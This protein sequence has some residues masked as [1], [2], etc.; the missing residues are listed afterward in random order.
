MSIQEP[1]ATAWLLLTSGALLALGVLM[2]RASRRVGVPVFLLFIALGMLAGSEGL[3]GIAFE[4]YHLSFRLGSIALALILFDGGLNTRWSTCKTAIRP[5]SVLATVGVAGTAVIVGLGAMLLG[6]DIWTAMLIGAVVSSTDAAAVF[7]TLR[8]SGL[9]LQKR[10]GTT[11]ELESGLNDPMAVILTMALTFGI[12]G[13]TALTPWLAVDIAVQLGVGVIVGLAMGALGR[14]IL[15]HVRLSAGGLYTVLTLGLAFSAFGLATIGKGS[16]FLAVYVAAVVIGNSQFPY[17][18]SL[19]RFHDAAAWLGQVAMF[20]LLGLL[21]FPSQLLE[22]GWRGLVLALVLV[23]VARP[24][25]VAMC[26]LPFGYTRREIGYIA[27]V[28]L[29]GAVPIVLATFPVLA[30]IDGA[31]EIFNMVFFVVVVTAIVPGGTVGWLT[32]RLNLT[33]DAPPPPPAVL[34]M[35]SLTQIDGEVMS[36]YIRP[37]AA[38]CGSAIRDIP[39]PDGASALLIVRDGKLIAPKGQT[40]LQASDHLYVFCQPVDEN[41]LALLFG[42]REEA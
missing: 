24:V 36:F 33:S 30:G 32:R 37:A 16:G 19:L 1:M 8:S 7:S 38:T 9:Q 23:F 14:W 31:G 10:V 13:Q 35:T 40:I 20:V 34:E 4:D 5:A 15:R 27:W 28:G 17:R 11:L 42:Q 41:L 25:V 29:R 21:V 22:V 26:L 18:S 3:G 12:A 2:S 39:F 6:F